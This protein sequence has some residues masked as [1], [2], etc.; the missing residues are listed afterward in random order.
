MFC[1]VFRSSSL[2]FF[3]VLVSLSYLSSASVLAVPDSVTTCLRSPVNRM[4]LIMMAEQL[5]KM[6]KEEEAKDKY[7]FYLFTTNY[8]IVCRLS[9]CTRRS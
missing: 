1:H 7:L 2:S 6:S 9:I 4:Y 3:Y 5:K 8:I